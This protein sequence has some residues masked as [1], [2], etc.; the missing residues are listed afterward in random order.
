MVCLELEGMQIRL[1]VMNRCGGIPMLFGAQIKPLQ[2]VII[3]YS[4]QA[5]EFDSTVFIV[6]IS[7]VDGDQV[8]FGTAISRQGNK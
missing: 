6:D 5:E 2:L 8:A 1:N 4:N 3:I 7:H